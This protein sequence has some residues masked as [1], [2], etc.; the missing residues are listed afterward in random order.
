MKKRLMLLASVTALIALLAGCGSNS[1]EE[2]LQQQ[3]NQL[4]QQIADLQQDSGNQQDTTASSDTGS[5]PDTNTDT[6]ADTASSTTDTTQENDLETLS[7]KVTDAV[8]SAD[9]T[10]PSGTSDENHTLYF[11]QKSALDALD[12][13]LDQYEDALEAQYRAGTL[14][15]TD[16]REQDREIEKLEDMLDDAEDRLE[17]RFGI[18]D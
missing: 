2:E 16:F 6:S 13:E 14:S 10:Q 1:R 18:D 17:N 4:E 15:Y 3:V 5:A 12:R 7:G 9:A 11:E 8:S